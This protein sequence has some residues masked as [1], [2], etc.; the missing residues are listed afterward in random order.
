M[1]NY[2]NYYALGVDFRGGVWELKHLLGRWR[3]ERGQSKMQTHADRF[4]YTHRPDWCVQTLEECM[5]F[6]NIVAD[7][8]I[9][10]YWFCPDLGHPGDFSQQAK[11]RYFWICVELQSGFVGHSQPLIFLNGKSI[12]LWSGTSN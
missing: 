5:N 7:R 2:H 8:P 12:V 10:G 11:K 1:I 3:A 6:D 4:K 9:I